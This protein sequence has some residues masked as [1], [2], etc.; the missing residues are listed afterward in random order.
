ML[1]MIAV[2]FGSE[3]I[4]VLSEGASDKV[5][6]IRDV[7]VVENSNE[8][9]MKIMKLVLSVDIFV[10]VNFMFFSL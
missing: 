1:L 4:A 2:I 3:E 5:C 6:D 7:P 10:C 9:I 8:S